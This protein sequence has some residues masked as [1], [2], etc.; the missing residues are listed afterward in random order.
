MLFRWQS[1]DQICKVLLDLYNSRARLDI[2]FCFYST[3]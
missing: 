3:I 2:E 1:I